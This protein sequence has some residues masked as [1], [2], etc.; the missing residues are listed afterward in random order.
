MSNTIT[1]SRTLV[2]RD[3][4][5]CGTTFA[6]SEYFEKRRR[7]DGEQFYCPNGHSLSFNDTLEKRLKKELAQERASHDQTRAQCRDEEDMH[8]DTKKRLSCQKGVTTRLKNRAKNGVCPCCNRSFA[9]LK[10]HMGSKH[11][12]YAVVP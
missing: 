9:N 11:P 10:R 1:V 5:V 3:C 8:D 7:D 4:A 6:I 12:G 2:P